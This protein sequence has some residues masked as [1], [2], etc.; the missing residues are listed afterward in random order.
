MVPATIEHPSGFWKYMHTPQE[1]PAGFSPYPADFF[2]SFIALNIVAIYKLVSR[3]TPPFISSGATARAYL[4]E[5]G[6]GTL[7]NHSDIEY[8][9]VGRK[10]QIQDCQCICNWVFS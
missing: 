4:V 9:G 8:A 5:N 6:T 7:Y 1:N 10:W 3:D 2:E